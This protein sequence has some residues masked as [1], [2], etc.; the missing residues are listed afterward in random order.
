MKSDKKIFSLDKKISLNEAKVRVKKLRQILDKASYSYHVLDKPILEDG[1]NDSLKNEL[2]ELE[3][4]FPALKTADSP[5]QRVGGEPLAKFKKVAHAKPLLSLEDAFSFL[6]LKEWEERDQRFLKTKNSFGYFSEVKVDGFA[7]SLV[8]ENGKLSYGATRGNGKIGE[9]V[10]LNLKTIESIPLALRRESKYFEEASRGRFEVRGEV[11]MPA[12]A[13]A[14]LNVERKKKKLSLFANPRNAAAGSIR[15]LNPRIAA[16]R[17]LDFFAYDILTDININNHHEA[18]D[19]A[20]DLGFPVIPINRLCQNLDEVEK[21]KQELDKR[22]KQ[23]NYWIDGVVIVIDNLKIFDKLGVAGK[24]PRAMI[25]YKFAPE[26]AATIL[27]DVIFNIGRTG[28]VNPVAILKP[29]QVAGTTVSRATLHNEDQIKKLDIKIGDTVVVVKA[30]DIIPKVMR[31]LKDLRPHDARGIHFPRT[32]PGC[33]GKLIK[34]GAYW[35]CPHKNCFTIK[36]RAIGHFVSKAAFDIEGLGP[37]ILISLMEQGLVK[38][39]ADLF[40]LRESDLEPLERFAE[41]SAANLVASIQEKKKIDLGRFLYSLGIRHVG[42][43]TA[44]DLANYFKILKQLKAASLEDLSQVENIGGIVAESV[45]EY[46]HDQNNLKDL[47]ELL[48][49]VQVVEFK[50]KKS[51][52]TGKSFCIT[53][54]LGSMSRDQAKEKIRELGGDWRSDVTSDLNY[55]I[56]GR[57]PGSKLEKAKKIRLSFPRLVRRSFSEGGRRESMPLIINEQEFLELIK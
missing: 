6:E 42:E 11:Y 14:K 12:T 9:D 32:C 29:V 19:I 13:F 16:S 22:R 7:V 5:T 20:R 44:I 34:K 8:Y 38:K 53:G 54:S 57:D 41:K 10:T 52:I 4:K 2:E 45:F 30:G 25:A 15:Q 46:F 48:K 17:E 3:K 50:I 28:M 18:H 1:V 55:L 35:Y 49:K 36:R 21:F 24:A 26:E 39:P 51:K 40:N 33:G 47:T 27:E 56:V 23:L 37:Q 43:Q 31:S